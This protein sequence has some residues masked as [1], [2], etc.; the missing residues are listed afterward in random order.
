MYGEKSLFERL[1]SSALYKNEFVQSYKLR[2]DEEGHTEDLI[3]VA[4]Y[5]NGIGRPLFFVY[6]LNDGYKFTFPGCEHLVDRN[7]ID[8]KQLDEATSNALANYYFYTPNK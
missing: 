3:V 8:F 4:G 1:Q 5:R 7:T 2:Y 6:G